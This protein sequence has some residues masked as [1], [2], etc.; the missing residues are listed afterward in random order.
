MDTEIVVKKNFKYR[1]YPSAAQTIALDTQLAEACRLYNAALQE[2]RDAYRMAGKSLNYCDQANQLKDIRAAGDL[3]LVNAQ[4]AQDVLRRLDKAFKAFFKRI[5]RGKTPGYPRFRSASR[6]DSITFPTYGDGAKLLDNGKLR[7][8]GVGQVKLKLHRPIEG[9][10]KTV[11]VKREAG[12]WYAV[13]SIECEPRPLPPS[14]EKA[15]L[16]VGLRAFAALSDGTEIENP[17]YYKEA[18][19]SLRRAQRKVARRKRGGNN[20]KK[21]VR[22]LQRAYAHVRNQ[23]ADFAHKVSRRLVILFGLIVIENLNIKG[24][25]AGMLAKSVN[26]AGWS[27]FITKLTY[28]AAEAGRVLLKVD[29][30]GTSQRCV[31]GAPNPKTLSQR[32]HN[33]EIC[34][35]SVPRDH[36]SALEILRLGLS[37]LGGT[38][39]VAA[40]VPNEAAL[41]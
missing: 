3:G 13:F 26:D 40:S 18:Q 34:G 1:L 15:G 9:T 4:C 21:A 31:C 25:A 41:L 27:S 12:K 10:I 16:D 17:R 33:C 32:W 8:Q 11:T 20:R 37:L 30:R 29:P 28:K 35:L 22:D 5:K 38:W 36:A 24:L 7:V 39:P 23:R 6:Y 14:T 19:A 2:R